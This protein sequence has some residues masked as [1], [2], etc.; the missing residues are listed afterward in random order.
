VVKRARPVAGRS[1][2]GDET[3]RG[4]RANSL[5]AA[6]AAT[7]ERQGHQ[8]QGSSGR[9]K[10]AADLQRAQLSQGQGYLSSIPLLEHQSASM[11][12]SAGWRS[13]E[14]EA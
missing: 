5:A 12:S 13:V 7:S 10:H 3:E 14:R 9:L 1:R 4:E 8:H 2:G 6:V 11:S